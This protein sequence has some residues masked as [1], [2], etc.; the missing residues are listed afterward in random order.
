MSVATHTAE[1]LIQKH[2]IGVWRYLR[3]LGCDESLSDDLTQETFLKILLKN[4]FN[5]NSDSETAAYLRRI[6]HNSLVSYH[7]KGGKTKVIVTSDPLDQVWNKW[8]GSD[9]SGEETIDQLKNCMEALGDRAKL[10]LKMRYQEEA[11]RTKIAATLGI[12]GHGARNLMQR[13][14]QQLRDCIQSKV[15][16]RN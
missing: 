15:K 4:D 13:A 2:Q 16:N 11:S 6:A 5:Q 7:R 3:M 8:A 14:K 12:T 1:E 9:I 10:A